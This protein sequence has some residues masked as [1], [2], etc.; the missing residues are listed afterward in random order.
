MKHFLHALGSWPFDFYLIVALLYT[1]LPVVAL[2]RHGQWIETVRV[3]S[4][5][6][7]FTGGIE[8]QAFDRTAYK[9]EMFGDHAM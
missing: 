1:N 2:I 4:S 9:Q 6:Q 8:V 5:S 3:L 7:L